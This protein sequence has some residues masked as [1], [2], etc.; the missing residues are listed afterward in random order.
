VNDLNLG[1]VQSRNP[2]E[3]QQSFRDSL[4]QLVEVRRLAGL[5]QLAD[6]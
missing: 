3:L 2:K 1:G 4:A 5:D 6:D